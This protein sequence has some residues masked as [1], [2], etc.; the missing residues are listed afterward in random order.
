[1]KRDKAF[2]ESKVY[3]KDNKLYTKEKTV[4]EFPKWYE[5]KGLA[6]FQEV[7]EVYGVFCVCIGDKYS[8]SVIPT[9]ISTK[10]IMIKEV[11]KEDGEVYVQCIYGKDDC[12]IE[13]MNVVKR[14]I[15]SYTFF[16]TFYMQ[17]RV[18]WYVEY[19]DVSRIMDNM[20][21]YGGSKLGENY[22]AS[23]IVT[24]FITRSKE[25]KKLF[26]R[27]NMGKDYEYV[28][29]MNV[30]HSLIGTTNKI[31][32]NYFTQSLVSGIVQKSDVS[33]KLEKHARA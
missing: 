6:N 11:E 21:K 24:S 26:Y 15:L 5:S 4:I 18:P 9:L 12:I 2:I 30:Y 33:T 7:T 17:S 20:L 19:V 28:D 25:N 22:I 3:I 13:N 8:V 27:Q 16:E 31:S 32:G 10:P 23:E 29:L 1:M 14:D